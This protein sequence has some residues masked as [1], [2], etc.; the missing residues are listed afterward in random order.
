[1]NCLSVFTILCAICAHSITI[2][3]VAY[4]S[5]L[6]MKTR[7]CSLCG[8]G[9]GNGVL[10]PPRHH[11]LWLEKSMKNGSRANNSNMKL[12]VHTDTHVDAPDHFYDNYYDASFDVDSLDL[13]LLNGLALL[14]DVPQDKNITA[15]VMKSLNIPRG[16]S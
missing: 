7:E 15:E 4:P 6:D 14:V 11:F 2:T 13:T 16:V 5:I 3:F 8:I 10:V 1:M 12:G 9:V